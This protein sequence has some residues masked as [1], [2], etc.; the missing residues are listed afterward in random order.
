MKTRRIKPNEEIQCVDF[1]YDEGF[2][3]RN[4]LGLVSTITTKN[5][6]YSGMPMIMKQSGGGELYE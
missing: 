1:R 2:R 4:D 6:G 5:S 3:G